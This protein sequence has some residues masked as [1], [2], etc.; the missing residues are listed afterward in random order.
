VAA[1]ADVNAD[2]AALGRAL[3]DPVL[4]L[5]GPGVTRL[6]I[7]PDGPLHRVPWDLLRLEDGR[8]VVERFA[9]GIAPSAGALALLRR[10]PLPAQAAGAVRVLAIGDPAFG[11][12][13][14]ADTELFAAAG[15]LP[16]LPGS[17][18]EAR[19]VARYAPAAE[20][21]LGDRASAAYLRQAPLD[22]FRVI[23]L[24]THAL[25]DDRAL[26]RTALAL[27]PGD[28]G[29]GLV[30]PNELA[31]LRLRAD[32][33]VLS[34]CRTAGGMAVDG[35]GLQGLT[36]P[37]LEAGA[38]SVVATSWRVGDRSTLRL[39]DGLY[40]G[41]AKGRPVIEA[42][43]EAKLGAMRSGAPPA[44]W[45]AF[46]LVGDPATMVPLT[47]PR[48]RPAWWVGAGCVILL[49]AATTLWRRRSR[50]PAPHLRAQGRAHGR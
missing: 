3:L 5:L 41:L 42:L 48:T 50:P 6:V 8:H 21:R 46:V 30:T 7:V 28:S 43:R 44:A 32:L 4:P 11:R 23:H 2:A 14:P 13:A 20:L 27:A 33:V 12:L 19:L 40:A 16:R 15:G 49:A 9:V 25:V 29:S 39:V 35:E 36:A 1:R 37:L 24:A 18:E 10:H 38:R 47:P 26:G 22:S 34:A 45:A 31:R 17:G